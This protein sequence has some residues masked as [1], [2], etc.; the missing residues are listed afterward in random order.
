MANSVKVVEFSPKNIWRAGWAVVGVV[1]CFSLL[2]FIFEDGGSVIFTVLISWFL[3]LAMEPAVSRLAKHMKRGFA[4]LITMVGFAICCVIFFV[5]FGALM[6][7]QIVQAISAF[8]D[9]V[10]NLVAWVNETFGLSLNTQELLNSANLNPDTIKSHAASLGTSVLSVIGSVIASFFSLFVIGLLTFYISADQPRLRRWVAGLFP[11]HIQRVVI[12][13]WDLTTEKTG[14][15]M[16]ARVVLAAINSITTGI[17][18]AIIGMPYWLALALW[19]GVVAQF[20]PTIGTYIA[21]ILPVIVGL[22]SG[23]PWI[24]VVALVWAIVYQQVENLTI[25]PRISAKAVN[26]HPAVA[27]ISVLLGASL[28][29]VTGAF[30][31]IPVTAMLLA[32]LELYRKRYTLISEVE[33]SDSTVDIGEVEEALENAPVG[34]AGDD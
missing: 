17:V 32:M 28:F 4:T 34:T 22:M 6:V 1:V 24:G 11:E 13:A 25:E 19:T 5:A 27:F 26:V 30:F 8:P 15:Y 9:I 7:D 23:E 29:G 31:A 12:T 10:A 16:G 2:Q 20:V 21:I 33:N 3:A 14:A 18:F